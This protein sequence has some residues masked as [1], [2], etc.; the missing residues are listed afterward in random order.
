MQQKTATEMW[1][2]L[3]SLYGGTEN[4]TIA[5]QQ[6]YRLQTVLHSTRMKAAQEPVSDRQMVDALLR[7]LPG[8]VCFN[9]L[10]RKCFSVKT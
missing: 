3:C 10:R 9:E 4:A 5:A 6:V 8:D 1:A 7:S 2:A